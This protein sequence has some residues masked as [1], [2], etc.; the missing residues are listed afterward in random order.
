MNNGQLVQELNTDTS[1]K[2]IRDHSYRLQPF[3]IMRWMGGLEEVEGDLSLLEW[4]LPE[5]DDSAWLAAGIVQPVRDDYGQLTPGNW[6]SDRF[7]CCMSA[8]NSS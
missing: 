1:W 7:R 6:R 2:S 8:S 3:P 4:T 5:Y